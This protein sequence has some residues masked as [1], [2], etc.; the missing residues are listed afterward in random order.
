IADVPE[1]R[2]EIRLA[3][4]ENARRLKK[5]IA[6]KKKEEEMKKKVIN[7]AKYIPEIARSLAVITHSDG[8][9]KDIITNKLVEIL[10]AKTGLPLV[11][12]KNA[13]ESVE[14]GV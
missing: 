9:D 3:I 13:I 10:V 14:I 12:V 11:E 5:Y 6:R 4:M 7:I 1:I 8:L 2:R